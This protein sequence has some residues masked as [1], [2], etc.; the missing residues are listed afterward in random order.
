MDRLNQRMMSTKCW[1]SLWTLIAFLSGRWQTLPPERE[2]G[3]RERPLQNPPRR[4][5]CLLFLFA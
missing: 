1:I 3:K 5:T 4:P 2:Q